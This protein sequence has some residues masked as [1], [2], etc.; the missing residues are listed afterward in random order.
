MW[1]EEEEFGPL[2]GGLGSRLAPGP[3]PPQGRPRPSV[4]WPGSPSAG[5]SGRARVV[6]PPLPGEPWRLTL[7][8]RCHSLGGGGGAPRRAGRGAGRLGGRGASQRYRRSFG[9]PTPRPRGCQAQ[10]RRERE[11]APRAAARRL[12]QVEAVVGPSCGGAFARRWR[13]RR[14]AAR[15]P[16]SW[17]AGQP[18]D[19]AEPGDSGDAA[20][21]AG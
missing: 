18:R 1:G 4:G 8:R 15:G 17:E 13:S 5:L 16:E 21:S 10:R 7:A 11:G 6:G 3:R 20:Q 9:C 14:D 12:P 2:G 19:V